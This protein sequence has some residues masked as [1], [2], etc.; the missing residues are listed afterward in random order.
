MSNVDKVCIRYKNYKGEIAWR[1]I[2]PK[3]IY[4]GYNDWHEEEQWLMIAYD[5]DKKAMRDFAMKD[6]LVWGNEASKEYQEQIARTELSI[7][8]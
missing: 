5:L 6:I 4:F 7:D 2:E 1:N 3:K 8:I